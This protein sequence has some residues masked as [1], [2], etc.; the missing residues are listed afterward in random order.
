MDDPLLEAVSF[1]ARAHRGQVRKDR[2]TPYVSHVFRVCLVMTSVFDVKDPRVLTAAVLHDVI[3]DTTT[4]FDD[5]AEKWGLEIAS[6]VQALSKD[7]RLPYEE[8][9]NA[10]CAGLTKA[11][12]PVQVCKLGDLYD[13]VVDAG[14]MEPKKRLDDLRTK[15]RRY[16][17]ALKAGLKP[18]AARAW[19][20]V[21]QL[22]DQTEASLKGAASR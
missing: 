2:E 15:K 6:W 7:K 19:Q 3:E 17:T 8:R 12:W 16:L 11:D 18:E 10:Y 21:S 14:Y 13:N 5:I 4:D 22:F 1:A 9:E 20:I